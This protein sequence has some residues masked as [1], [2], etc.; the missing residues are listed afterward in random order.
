MWNDRKQSYKTCDDWNLL[1]FLLLKYFHKLN[2]TFFHGRVNHRKCIIDYVI[3]NGLQVRDILYYYLCRVLQSWDKRPN[4][5]FTW[6]NMSDTLLLWAACSSTE[7][8]EGEVLVRKFTATAAY[9]SGTGQHESGNH[10]SVHLC[11][12]SA[13]WGWMQVMWPSYRWEFIFCPSSVSQTWCNRR[14]KPTKAGAGGFQVCGIKH[15][16][17]KAI[18][19]TGALEM[20]VLSLK[21]LSL[22]T[23]HFIINGDLKKLS[24]LLMQ[25]FYDSL[26]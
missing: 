17:H 3:V 13:L 21:F 18:A 24:L 5:N 20:F 4:G 15:L 22:L 26:L 25:T 23:L 10:L 9:I 7:M 1:S 12:V 14:A 6:W 11:T 19:V 8:P 16:N 2:A